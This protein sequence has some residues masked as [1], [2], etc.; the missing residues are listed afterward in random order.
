VAPNLTYT[1]GSNFNG[2]D[3][4]TF[5]AN[6]G[7]LDSTPATVSIT[8]SPVND[9]PTISEIPDQTIPRRSTTGPIEFVVGD[10]D[11]SA[12]SLSV[13]ATSSDQNLVPDGNIILGGSG[14]NR[15]STVTPADKL[16]GTTVITV[17]VSD[18]V[19]STSTSFTLTVTRSNRPPKADASASAKQV[20]SPN[21]VNAS[22]R[23]DGSRS[24]DP[25]GD[26]LTYAWFAD[27]NPTVLG[28]GVVGTPRLNV[29][30][31][32]ILLRVNDG[33]D[34][35]EDRIQ[36]R[37]ITAAEATEM[38]L[39]HLRSADIPKNKEKALAEALRNAIKDFDR[40]RMDAGD[41][42]LRQFQKAVQAKDGKN[43]DPATAAALIAEAQA[44]IDAVTGS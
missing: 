7:A 44:I 26:A 41:K 37:I 6:D 33:T 35:A 31:H 5:K 27:R 24:S 30:L 8:I 20:I 16:V 13:S 1:P 15:T 40:G 39:E 17:T 3:S 14:A 36:V 21:N 4:F 42:Q 11:N 43:I 2:S 23:L 29:G 10:V 28:T 18:G 25:D 38:L 19:N 32:E 9:A 34:T 12:D 22:V